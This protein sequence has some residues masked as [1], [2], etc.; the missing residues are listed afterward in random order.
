MRMCLK[1]GGIAYIEYAY[2]AI[3]CRS[4]GKTWSIQQYEQEERGEKKRSSGSP[5]RVRQEKRTV[6]VP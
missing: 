4:C 3:V 6:V 5:L 2:Q 1:C